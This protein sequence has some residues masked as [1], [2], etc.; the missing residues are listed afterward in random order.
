MI[1]TGGTSGSQPLSLGKYIIQNEQ[2]NGRV[3]YQNMI[4][5]RYMYWISDGF[6]LLR[7]TTY[8]LLS[9]LNVFGYTMYVLITI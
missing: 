8:N 5:G 9:H 6:L 7:W 3:D 4:T 1:S 2:V